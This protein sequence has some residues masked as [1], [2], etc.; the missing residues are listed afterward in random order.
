[1]ESYIVP[2]GMTVIVLALIALAAS[3]VSMLFSSGMKRPK[4][5]AYTLDQEWTRAPAL[6]SA[7]EIEPMA[8]PRPFQPSDLE[9]GYASGKW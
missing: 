7:T 8:L 9:G 2:I 5:P 1:M 4:V 6:Y 3:V